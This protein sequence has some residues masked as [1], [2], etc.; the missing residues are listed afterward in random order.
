[1]VINYISRHLD[2]LSRQVYWK[3]KLK[4][5]PWCQVLLMKGIIMIRDLAVRAASFFVSTKAGLEVSRDVYIYGFELIFSN[6]LFL[7]L[8]FILSSF[9]NSF[10]EMLCF[11]LFFFPV[12]G[13]AGG[14]HADSHAKCILLSVASCLL[15]VPIAKYLTIKTQ[16]FLSL[17]FV[18]MALLLIYFLA[19]TI[20]FNN[21]LTEI[22]IH[23]IREISIIIGLIEGIA[24]TIGLFTA[25]RYSDLLIC[26]A[27]GSFTA[28]ISL[29][30]ANIKK[31]GNYIWKN[32]S[33]TWWYCVLISSFL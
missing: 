10:W 25:P 26:A 2:Y 5:I 9:L 31:G 27:Y 29:L 19:P 11:L 22:E 3:Q 17:F 15:V 16:I 13:F 24:I 1:M 6:V 32:L 23:R 21:P 28:G 7:S 20:H 12:R 8:V 33:T 14:Y 18:L 4:M 30:Y